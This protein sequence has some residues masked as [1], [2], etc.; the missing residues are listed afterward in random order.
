MKKT[1]EM[2]L[3]IL[4]EAGID[5]VFGLPG[6]STPFIF[7]ALFDRQ[8]KLKPVLARQEGAAAC[9]ADVYGRLTGKPGVVICQGPWAGSNA[10]FGIMEAYS[11]GSPMLIITDQSDWGNL[12]QYG[13]YQSC[14]GEYGAFDLAGIM[15]R[16]TKY[17]CVANTAEEFIRGVQL[18]IKHA[19]TGKPGPAAVIAKWN[20]V[21]SEFEPAAVRPKIYPLA[22]YLAVSPASITE[23]DADKIAA[24]IAESQKPVMIC[25]R[26]IHISRAYAE[27]V[28][29][30][31]LAGLPVATSYM[32]K[33]SI[34]E[35]HELAL[36]T[37]G[38]LGQKIANET[39]TSAD[40]ILAVGTGLSPENNRMLAPEFINPEKQKLIHIDI[41]PLNAGF[42]LP[43]TLGATSDA[44][45]ALRAIIAALKKRGMKP[46]QPRVAELKK[47]KSDTKF[48]ASAAELDSDAEPIL[49]ERVVKEVNKLA[50]KN[51][52]LVLDGGNNRMW[53]TKHFQTGHAGQF[54]AP[55]GVAAVGWCPP[56]ALAAQLLCK[57]KRVIGISGDGGMVMGLHCLVSARQYNV[58]VTYLV[59]NN[60]CLG[61]VMDFMAPNRRV[62]A[63]YPAPE[64]AAIAQGAGLK[65]VKVTRPSEIA[66]ALKQAL[67][68]SE[69]TL[70][71]IRVSDAPH[72]RLMGA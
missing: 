61:N 31:E 39:I 8:D 49:P 59:L 68:G 45:L 24:M 60:S 12:G 2:V 6:G 14:T 62:C 23:E 22:G 52:M 21:V 3:D 48:F 56:A 43:V 19:T 33:S 72:F 20:T 16:I 55:G 32:G 25:G 40:L 36:G 58:P 51:T 66:P 69:P 37:T 65:G 70:L 34:P 11:A 46:C 27:V 35:T 44:K 5:H 26:G 54:I 15:R 64:L 63:Q 47:L 28:E 53:F 17:T 41:E 57:D 29:L 18:G 71:D 1:R 38:N 50:D 4:V 13:V 10:G 42:T 30:A 7:D 67:D 9:M